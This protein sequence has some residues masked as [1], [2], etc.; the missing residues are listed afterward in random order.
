[1]PVRIFLIGLFSLMVISCQDEPVSVSR[2]SDDNSRWMQSLLLT[3][4]EKDI[5]LS[6]ICLPGAHDAGTYVFYHCSFGANACNTRTQYLSTW[7][8]LNAG[9]R[10]FDIR[11]VFFNNQLFTQHATDC[12]GL[13]CK[14]DKLENICK[15]L[16]L[17]LD[18]HAEFV[19]F[20]IS[21]FCGTSYTDT[22][23]TNLLERTL[24]DRIYKETATSG[25]PFIQRPLKTIIPP[26]AGTGKVLLL[27]EGA[28]NTPELRA[29]G[30]FSYDILPRSGGWSNSHTFSDLQEK[31]LLNYSLFTAD[32]NSLFGFSWQITQ[33]EAMAVSC[34]FDPE[35]GPSIEKFGRDANNRLGPIVDS[36][37]VADAIR[38]GR[39]PNI[40]YTDFSDAAIGRICM[41]I[42]K[43]NLE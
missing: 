16:R 14:G 37:I 42:S 4:P 27:T 38:P 20:E 33:D 12:N 1:M 13:G 3:Y 31:Q 36:L 22:A 39:I 34:F 30:I 6:D 25:T 8:M 21:H 15:Q 18:G 29:A 40:I 11:P 7:D 5:T 19:I 41:Q 32:G 35:N 2:T 28:P 24:G 43:V 10:M 26:A 17:F 9:I 23:F